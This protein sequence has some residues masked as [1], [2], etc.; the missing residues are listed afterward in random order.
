MSDATPLPPLRRP[1]ITRPYRKPPLWKRMLWQR[2][3]MPAFWT[4][5]GM[6]SLVVNIIL[7]II[8]WTLVQQLFTL[9]SVVND[10]LVTGLYDNFVKM[11]ESVI[12]TQI[13]VEDTIPVVF[14]LPLQQTT[15]VVIVEDTIIP[16]TMVKIDTG[17]L[18]INAPATITLPSGTILAAA[19][20][21]EVPVDTE[22]PVTLLVDV[23]IPLNE[24]DL[25][26]P[27]VGLQQVIAPYSSLLSEA[28]DSWEESLC[29]SSDGSAACSLGQMLDGSEDGGE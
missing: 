26:A 15:N 28:P 10:Q 22:I 13:L 9:K 4:V 21:L 14:T 19:L 17:E 3:F 23:S 25:R 1:P 2:K 16:E 8:V 12:S 6:I 29:E 7:I 18:V 11:E 27:F 5:T 20:D 24:T